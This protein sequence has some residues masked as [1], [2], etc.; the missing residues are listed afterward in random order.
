[1]TRAN[2]F[3]PARRI[4]LKNMILAVATAGAGI[5]LSRAFAQAKKIAQKVVKYQDTPRFKRKC[6]ECKFW[7][8]K[9]QSCEIVEG[10]VSPNGW[11]IRWTKKIS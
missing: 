2:N 5:G 1:M 8:A 6:D 7:V 10:T 11:C 3:V 4:F 9:D